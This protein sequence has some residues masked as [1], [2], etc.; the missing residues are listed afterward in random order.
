MIDNASCH[1]KEE[2]LS[3]LQHVRVLY[4]PKKTT[5]RLQ[6]MNARVI[7]CI[8]HRYRRR[9]IERAID[10]LKTGTT[11]NLYGTDL[12]RSISS[13]YEIW[14][15]IECSIVYNC[16]VKTGLLSNHHTT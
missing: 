14:N 2:K 8:K 3:V 9:Q 12:F 11:E 7:A 6:P 16:W 1:G 10:L 4:L 5:S 13:I 15:Q